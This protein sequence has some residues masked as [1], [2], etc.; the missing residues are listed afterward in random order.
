[1]ELAGQSLGRQR[2]MQ[3]V[4]AIGD[5]QR[6]TGGALGEEITHGPIHRPRD[7]D[8]EAVVRDQRKRAVDAAH[9]VGI[10]RQHASSSLVDIHV[11][12]HVERRVEEI[13]DAADGCV[14]GERRPGSVTVWRLVP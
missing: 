5:E 12:D 3:R 10:A 11:V 4:D 9:G 8:G 1:M 13:D 7:A 2:L 6:R 14:H